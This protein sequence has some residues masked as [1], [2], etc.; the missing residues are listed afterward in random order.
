LYLA[1][2]IL[3]GALL[4]YARLRTRSRQLTSAAE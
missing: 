3:A 1:D 4:I 2:V